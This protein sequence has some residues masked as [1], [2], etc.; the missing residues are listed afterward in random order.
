MGTPSPLAVLLLAMLVALRAP[1][2][3]QGRPSFMVIL[4]DDLGWGDLGAN[5]AQTKETPNL[6]ELAARGTR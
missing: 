6:D 3:A 4:A 5:W 2:A 1:P